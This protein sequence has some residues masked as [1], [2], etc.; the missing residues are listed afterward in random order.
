MKNLIFILVIAIV[1]FSSVVYAHPSKM[2]NNENL[3]KRQLSC[4]KT[5]FGDWICTEGQPSCSGGV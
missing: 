3:A 5:R 2:E 4:E 1:T